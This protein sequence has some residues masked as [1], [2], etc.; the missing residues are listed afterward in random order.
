M[1]RDSRLFLRYDAM[2][3]TSLICTTI[4]RGLIIFGVAAA[5]SGCMRM[6]TGPNTI[7]DNQGFPT[8][9]T[10]HGDHGDFSRGHD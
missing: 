8:Y 6:H 4:H 5:I 1:T 2:S 10:K 9:D 3:I 7:P